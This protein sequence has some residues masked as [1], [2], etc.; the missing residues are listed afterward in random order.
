MSDT[1]NM[2]DNDGNSVD[3]FLFHQLL[4][5]FQALALQQLG[6]LMNPISGKVERDLQQAKIT[7]DMIGMIQKKTEG[8][9]KDSEKKMI[10]NILLDLRMNYVDESNRPDEG[11]EL[12]MEEGKTKETKEDTASNKEHEDAAGE[13]ADNQQDE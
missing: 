13:A 8:N 4:A 7:I 9:L 5:M 12:D 3:E 2:T 10:E 11:S 6:K 1:E